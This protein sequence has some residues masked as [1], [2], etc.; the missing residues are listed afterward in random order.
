MSNISIGRPINI[1]F[2][3]TPEAGKT[4]QFKIITKRLKEEGFSVTA[5]KESAEIIPSCFDKDSADANRWLRLETMNELLSAN[6]CDVD[7]VIIDRGYVD[8][9]IWQKIFFDN[10]K[11]SFEEFYAY[12]LYFKQFIP[13]PDILFAFSIPPSLSIKRRGGEGRIT[14]KSFVSSY[15]SQV[16]SFLES[17]KG[18]FCKVDATLPIEQV[19]QLLMDNIHS[20]L[21]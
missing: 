7:I 19:S 11:I 16:R 4:T 12:N 17:Y 20:I 14:T 6:A 9:S 13:E 1:E 2:T 5:I 18:R 15:N 3:G 10:G 21:P 8:G